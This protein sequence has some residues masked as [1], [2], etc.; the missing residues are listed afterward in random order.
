M[1]DLKEKRLAKGLTQEQLSEMV[2]IGRK[3]ISLYECGKR[4]PSVEMAKLL[5]KVLEF[6]WTEIF[7]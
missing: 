3:S 2:F 7:E 5:G 1:V 4:R 6:D